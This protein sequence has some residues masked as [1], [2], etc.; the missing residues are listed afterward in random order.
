MLLN[1]SGLLVTISEL[2]DKIV[3]QSKLIML[4]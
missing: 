2:I 1:E 3:S 4:Q